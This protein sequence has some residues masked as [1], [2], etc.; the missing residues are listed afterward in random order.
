VPS[1]LPC[2]Q[3]KRNDTAHAVGMQASEME[4]QSPYMVVDAYL[5]TSLPLP[6]VKCGM[7]Y[8]GHVSEVIFKSVPKVGIGFAGLVE[9]LRPKAFRPTIRL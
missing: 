2:Q 6:S 8:P 1:C 3:C 7:G 9:A 5:Q 4:A